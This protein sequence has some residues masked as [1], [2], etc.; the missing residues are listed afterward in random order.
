MR[1]GSQYD[2]EANVYLS[3]E[4]DDTPSAQ[5]EDRFCFL[6]LFCASGT[7]PVH[8]IGIA[9]HRLS[10]LAESAPSREG[11]RAP[12]SEHLDSWRGI[13]VSAGRVCYISVLTCAANNHSSA[14]SRVKRGVWERPHI[15]ANTSIRG[16]LGEHRQQRHIRR[17]YPPLAPFPTRGQGGV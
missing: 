13:R 8:S 10:R 17:V 2:I 9:G 7:P 14:T 4:H 16:I 5:D 3:T 12:P 15:I 6:L 11:Q 1:G